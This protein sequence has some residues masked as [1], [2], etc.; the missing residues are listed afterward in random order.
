MEAGNMGGKVALVTAAGDF[1]GRA[2]ALRLAEAGADL[3]LLDTDAEGLAETA[4]AARRFGFR[5]EVV[6]TNIA[7]PAAC[8]A[9]VDKAVAHFGRLDAVCNVA[10]VFR[11]SRST[12]T[13]QDDW[14]QSLA[15][16]LSAPF[17]LTQAALPH[18]LTSEGAVVTVISCVASLAHPYTAAY[19]ASKAGVAQMTRALAIEYRS[20]KVRINLVSFGGAALSRKSASTMP[21][22]LDPKLFQKFSSVRPAIE[23]CE[24]A[25][26][27]AFLVS[28]AARG[29]HG[30]CVTIDNGVTLG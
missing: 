9:A 26:V 21:S 13:S 28:D 10:N 16:N 19:S 15:I 27:I 18:L 22:D 8:R 5:A 17:Y 23:L 24:V 20:E 25:N 7:E 1:L 11:P 29:F 30:T 2:T 4:E 12:E 14:E 3:C 6:V